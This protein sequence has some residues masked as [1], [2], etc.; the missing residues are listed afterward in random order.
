MKLYKKYP[1][2]FVLSKY[3]DMSGKYD[4]STGL[5]MELAEILSNSLT[6]YLVTPPKILQKIMDKSRTMLSNDIAEISVNLNNEN[7][8]ITM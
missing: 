4:K 3:L 7:N 5:D 6:D 2:T 1:R 8:C